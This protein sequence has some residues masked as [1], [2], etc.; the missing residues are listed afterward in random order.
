[1]AAITV[2]PTSAASESA[3]T[4]LWT[5]LRRNLLKTIRV[6]QLLLSSMA[7]PLVMLV[8]FSQVFR[9]IASAERFPRAWRTSTSS[10]RRCWPC[11]R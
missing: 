5:L 6:P 11:P 2:S 4:Q 9:T 1:M 8:L 7:M 3:V 10:P